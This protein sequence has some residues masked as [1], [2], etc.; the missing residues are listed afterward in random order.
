MC[1]PPSLTCDC[2]ECCGCCCLGCAFTLGVLPLPAWALVRVW[3]CRL[4]LGHGLPLF[5]ADLDLEK[6]CL[7]KILFEKFLSRFVSA[8]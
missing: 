1:C 6:I 5:R 8:F 4:S 2:V 7:E 3:C